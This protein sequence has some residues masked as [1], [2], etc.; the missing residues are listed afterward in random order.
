MT[1][2]NNMKDYLRELITK[3]IDRFEANGKNY[4]IENRW[5]TLIIDYLLQYYKYVG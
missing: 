3:T 4:I 1:C 5:T 2:M